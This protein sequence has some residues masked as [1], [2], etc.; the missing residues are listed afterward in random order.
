MITKA[1]PFLRAP[2]IYPGRLSPHPLPHGT[3]LPTIIIITII[4]IIITIIIIT[5][6]A[7]Q[8]QL[9]QILFPRTPK[10][11]NQKLPVI[12]NT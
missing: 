7:L 2:P 9:T 3:N 4:I 5:T 12:Y 11:K 8:T 1:L 10:K 6:I